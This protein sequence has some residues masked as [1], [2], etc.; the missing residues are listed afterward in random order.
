MNFE[1]YVVPEDDSFSAKA[2]AWIHNRTVDAKRVITEHPYETLFVASGVFGVLTKTITVVGKSMNL[3]K[4]QQ[5]KDLYIW[6]AK[7]G[8]HWQMRKKPSQW[9]QL[10]I[11]RRQEAGERLG[12]ILESL[13]LLK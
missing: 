5:I 9:Q 13:D 4:E 3:R 6:D 2:K 1:Y 12:S 7:L 10:E 11:E 8:R